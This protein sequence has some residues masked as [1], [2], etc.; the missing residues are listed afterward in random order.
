[1]KQNGAGEWS[2]IYVIVPKPGGG[3]YTLDPVTNKFNSEPTFTEKK[4]FN[5]ALER[6]SGLGYE[7]ADLQC[8]PI[9]ALEFFTPTKQVLSAEL[10]PTREY[11]LDKQIAFV[12]DGEKV[13][14]QTKEGAV[15]VPS[16]LTKQQAATLTQAVSTNPTPATPE[17]PTQAKAGFGWL[18]ALLLGGAVLG[19][20]KDPKKVAT[21]GMAGIKATKQKR[22]FKT[23]QL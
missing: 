4:D 13:V 11:L 16:I 6:L 1:M 17:A 12:D 2:H 10:V 19:S 3:Y 21:G 22:K 18:L 7:A 20:L 9:Q 14:V 23:L 15:S 8:K 5:M